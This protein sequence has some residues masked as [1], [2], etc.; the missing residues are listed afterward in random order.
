[1]IGFQRGIN[2]IFSLFNEEDNIVFFSLR[3]E[4]DLFIRGNE[5][6]YIL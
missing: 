3:S 1:M 5:T 6:Q 2:L 4:N